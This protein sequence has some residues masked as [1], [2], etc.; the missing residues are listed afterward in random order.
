MPLLRATVRRVLMAVPLLF[1]ISVLSF[2][3]VSL[4]P[5]DTAQAILGTQATQEQYEA[6]RSSLGLDLPLYEQYWRWLSHAVTGDL[7]SSLF[8]GETVTNAILTRLPVTL[9]LMFGALLVSLVAGVA[10]GVFSAVR[11]GV[12][13]R[14]VDGIALVGF[15]LPGFWVGAMLI[16]VFAVALRWLP[17]TGYVDFA[18]SP[19]D[20]LRSLVLPVFALALSGIAALA[21]QTRESMLDVLNSEY[22]RMARA[23]GVK[24]R[25]IVFVNA[26]KNASVRVVT[27]LGLQ[28]V[29]LLGGTVVVENVFALPGLGSLAVN[30]TAQHDLPVIQGIVVYFTILVVVINLLVDLAYTWLNPKVRTS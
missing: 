20:W 9:S 5:G 16:V 11:G 1:V 15:A 24:Y 10:L 21:K 19:Q 25:S 26:L 17:P 7:G 28:A 18:E 29:A 3:L 12:L 4:T 8:S 27:I 23:N 14:L 13:G 2:V 30:S 6:L 22:I